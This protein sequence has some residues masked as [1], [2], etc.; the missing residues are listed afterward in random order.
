MAPV[1][2][3]REG[4][5]A[6]SGAGP[7]PTSHRHA[8]PVASDRGHPSNPVSCSLSSIQGT[9]PGGPGGE[10]PGRGHARR[11]GRAPIRPRIAT[12]PRLRATGATPRAPVGGCST[13]AP[14]GENGPSRDCWPFAPFEE[15]PSSVGDR[16]RSVRGR[17][18]DRIESPLRGLK[19]TA[20]TVFGRGISL[21]SARSESMTHRAIID[22]DCQRVLRMN[23]HS[24]DHH[25]GGEQPCPENPA[26]MSC[27]VE[28]LVQG[29]PGRVG[30]RSA[31]HRASLEGSVGCAA[32]TH[33]TRDRP[34]SVL[35]L[36]QG[37][38]RYE[39]R[40]RPAPHPNPKILP[41]SRVPR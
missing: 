14:F 31:T 29:G 16:F 2:S 24:K 5:R 1:A 18:E 33:P 20:R 10:Q 26:M 34:G 32:P 19:P 27:S 13:F 28:N 21:H 23:G 6:P 11:P 41:Q 12:R 25:Q 15:G 37:H 35:I 38:G 30:R 7:D 39:R 17:R 22:S 8:P 4:T 9:P 40:V 36:I 3:N